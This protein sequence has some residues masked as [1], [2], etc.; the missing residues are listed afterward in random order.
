MQC[1]ECSAKMKAI[2]ILA[3]PE[4]NIE[5]RQLT[6]LSQVTYVCES[7]VLL[8]AVQQPPQPIAVPKEIRRAM[9]RIEDWTVTAMNNFCDSM[10][11]EHDIDPNDELPF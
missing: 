6:A 5:D 11:T 3:V 7:C 2:G 1:P 9:R 4:V 10:E 8:V